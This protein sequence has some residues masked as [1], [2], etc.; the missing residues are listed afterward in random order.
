MHRGN[1]TKIDSDYTLKKTDSTIICNN[2]ANDISIYLPSDAVVGTFYRIIKKGKTV[3]LISSNK[4]IGLVN[5]IDLKSRVSSGTA[6]EWINC[7]WDGDC[8]NIEM[9]RS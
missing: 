9:S 3:T 7:L 5:N 8:W 6:R 2:T 4:N 1:V